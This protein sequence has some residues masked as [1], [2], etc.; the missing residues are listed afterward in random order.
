MV[1]RDVHVAPRSAV[2][3]RHRG[4][5]RMRYLQV[6]TDLLSVAGRRNL[7]LFQLVDLWFFVCHCNFRL[8][9]TLVA[10]FTEGER[11]S[12]IGAPGTGRGEAR[13]RYRW[14]TYLHTAPVQCFGRSVRIRHW[15]GLA[16]AVARG[17]SHGVD[18]C[19]QD[20]AMHRRRPCRQAGAGR[21]CSSHH[22]GEHPAY[23]GLLDAVQTPARCPLPLKPFVQHTC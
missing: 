22:G 5:D 2:P 11:R 6:C 17:H 18:R 23:V 16:Q 12:L 14:R 4:G 1:A 9:G 13:R 21:S 10:D 15:W 8:Y 19:A 20:H 3:C 7:H